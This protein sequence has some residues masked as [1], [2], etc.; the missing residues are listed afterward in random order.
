[1]DDVPTYSYL[2]PVYYYQGRD[3][4]DLKSPDF[5]KFYRTYLDIRGQSTQDPLV[6]DI[7]K[8]LSH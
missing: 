4:Q 5:D 2:A 8:R 3:R 6:A 7:R 1:M